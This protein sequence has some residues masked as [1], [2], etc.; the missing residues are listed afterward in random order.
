M[1]AMQCFLLSKS[2][3]DE[4]STQ[5]SVATPLSF[6]EAFGTDKLFFIKRENLIK[7]EF[8]KEEAEAICK[9]L[10]VNQNAKDKLIWNWNAD[11][12][13]WVRSGYSVCFNRLTTWDLIELHETLYGKRRVCNNILPLGCALNARIQGASFACLRCGNELEDIMHALHECPIAKSALALSRFSTQ[14]YDGDV[15]SSFF[16]IWALWNSRNA[17][18]FRNSNNTNVRIVESV[19]NCY[20]DFTEANV[21]SKRT[22]GYSPCCQSRSPNFNFIKVNFDASFKASN[23]IGGV[24]VV[25]RDIERF[26]VGVTALKLPIAANAATAEAVAA[27]KAIETAI[28]MGFSYVS[29]EGDARVILKG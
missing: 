25:L 14:I 10:L 11:G 26:V 28:D 13:Y 7:R 8:S 5:V 23:N 9:I 16:F 21:R 18:F 4:I 3:R 15:N 22:Y 20:K 24:G 1:Y 12:N 2:L 19:K 17:S 27:V 6:G 29:I